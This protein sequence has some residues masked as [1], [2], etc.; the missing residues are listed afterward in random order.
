MDSFSDLRQRQQHDGFAAHNGIQVTR[1]WDGFAEGE[2]TI[3]PDSLNPQGDVHGG[4]LVALADTVAGT[5]AFSQAARHEKTCVT[6][7]SSFNYL[8]PGRGS[9]LFCRAEPQRVGGTVAVYHVALTDDQGRTV[10][11]GC[12]TFYFLAPRAPTGA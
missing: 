10:A 1:V 9:K 11:T 3:T 7:Q 5:A 2:L 6:L 8:L 4:C 12:F